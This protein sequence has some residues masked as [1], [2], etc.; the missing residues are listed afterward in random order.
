M[1]VLAL[2]VGLRHTGWRNTC[3]KR[4]PGGLLNA[5]HHRYLPS[6]MSKLMQIEESQ[7]NATYPLSVSVMELHGEG[8]FLLGAL[9]ILSWG[10]V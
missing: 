9:Y 4:N 5:S 7:E 6:P 3:L 2:C 1:S 10:G 8:S